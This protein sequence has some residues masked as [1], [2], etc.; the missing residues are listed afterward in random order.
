VSI[1]EVEAALRKVLDIDER[2]RASIHAVIT[3][4]RAA[5]ERI[6]RITVGST[7]PLIRRTLTQHT[8]AIDK[9]EQALADL[10]A[11]HQGI[12]DYLTTILGHAASTSGTALPPADTGPPGGVVPEDPAGF[13]PEPYWARMLRFDPDSGTRPK[14]HGR[15]TDHTGV[16]HDLLSGRHDGY[17]TKVDQ[18]AVAIGLIPAGA[19][20]ARSGDIEIRFAVRMRETWQRTGSPPREN[21]VINNPNGPCEGDL[22]CDTLLPRCLPPGAELTVHWPGGTKTYRGEDN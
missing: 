18:H 15:W 22:G 7:H 4:L 8:Q 9:A 3:R 19:G 2:A 14:T 11:F 6:A 16:T 5:R 20:L 1:A 10:D 21:I 17:H 12:T 13:D